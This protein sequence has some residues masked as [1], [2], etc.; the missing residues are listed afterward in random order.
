MINAVFVRL[1]MSVQHRRV[2]VYSALVNLG[3][4]FKPAFAR[5]LV[6][7]D[8][9]ASRFADYLSSPAWTTIKPRC[10]KAINH[11]LVCHPAGSRQV[12]QLYHGERLQMHARKV[13]LELAQK[14][15]VVIKLQPRMKPP[16]YVKFS[17]SF[18]ISRS[19]DL[20]TLLHRPLV[21]FRVADAA[22]EAAKPTIGNTHIGVVHVAINVEVR[23]LAVD[24]LSDQVRERTNGN[25]VVALKECH[26]I[27]E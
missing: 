19:R 22:I 25:Q 20:D 2:C 11:F 21:G 18:I 24:P 10:D 6:R 5:G 12:V 17:R 8:L 27:L 14:R 3:G 23:L 4:Q 7:A 9:A 26:S 13:A 1:D 16:D 15:R